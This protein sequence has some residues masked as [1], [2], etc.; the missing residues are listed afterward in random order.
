MDVLVRILPALTVIGFAGSVFAKPRVLVV[1]RIAASDAVLKGRIADDLPTRSPGD[2]EPFLAK[3]LADELNSLL[4]MFEFVTSGTAA[5]TIRFELRSHD[6][7]SVFP[8]GEVDLVMTAP[9]APGI[10]PYVMDRIFQRSGCTGITGCIS[11]YVHT[12]RYRD[13]LHDALKTWPP[14]VKQI[15]HSIPLDTKATYR[16]GVIETSEAPDDLGETALGTPNSMFEILYGTTRR[17]FAICD[18]GRNHRGSLGKEQAGETVA[19][20]LIGGLRTSDE[21]ATDGVV[22]LMK[23]WVL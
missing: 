2:V 3:E 23:A 9:T 10:A 19:T 18:V 15:F 5:F 7:T 16:R 21:S 4:R 13:K 6:A 1:A 14:Q 20:C 22:S 12:S 17:P 8:R 11:D